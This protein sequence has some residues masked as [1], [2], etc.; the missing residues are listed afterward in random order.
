MKLALALSLSNFTSGT[1]PF[2]GPLDG[3]SANAIGLWSI[4]KRLLT[5]YTGALIRVRRSSDNAE[6]D[7]G[8][9]AA[10]NLDSAALTSFVGGGSWFLRWVYDETGNGHH[11]GNSTAAAQPQGA[12]DGNGLAYAYAPGAGFTTTNLAR[13]GLSIATTDTTHWTVHSSAGFQTDTISTRTA[14]PTER[15]CGNV[16]NAIIAS[17]A[18]TGTQATL[19]GTNTGLYTLTFQV[20]GGGHRISNG[21]ASATGTQA[22][23]SITIAQIGMG[24]GGGGA[25]WAQNSKFY[26]GG[27]WSADLGNTRSDA[28]NVIGKSLFVTQ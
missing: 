12:I 15:R 3:F 20:G 4:S 28:L 5:S 6:S 2:V 7:I 18:T 22:S 13:S 23:N 21:L 16:S 9:D 11:I 10:G 1:P 26:A 14:V 24:N 27:L 17:V 25:S 8:A 19:A